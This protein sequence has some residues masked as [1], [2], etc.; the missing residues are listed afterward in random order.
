MFIGDYNVNTEILESSEVIPSFINSDCEKNWVYFK[1]AKY[2][3]ENYL[4]YGWS[5]LKICKINKEK[6]NM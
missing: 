4:I 1:Y 5:P 2:Y 6:K 3:N